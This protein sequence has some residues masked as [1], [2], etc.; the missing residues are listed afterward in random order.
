M[1][2]QSERSF[3]DGGLGD[4][5]LG[6]CSDIWMAP[7]WKIKVGEVRWGCKKPVPMVYCRLKEEMIW[8]R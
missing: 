6:D 1:F 4:G 3:E 5:G 7:F 2:P 8:I